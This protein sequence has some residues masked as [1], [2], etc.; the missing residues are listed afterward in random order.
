MPSHLE[1]PSLADRWGIV[2]QQLRGAVTKRC[3]VVAENVQ[4]QIGMPN[5]RRGPGVG[6]NDRGIL[7]ARWLGRLGR[8]SEEGVGQG[9]HCSKLSRP[10]DAGN[11]HLI[12]GALKQILIIILLGKRTDKVEPEREVSSGVWVEGGAAQS[13]ADRDQIGEDCGSESGLRQRSRRSTYHCGCS[14]PLSGSR[15]GAN[16]SGRDR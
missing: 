11:D 10:A 16:C 6:E 3:P 9:V 8:G 1:E 5:R 7:R 12:A 14:G 2:G 4:I 15:G 13:V